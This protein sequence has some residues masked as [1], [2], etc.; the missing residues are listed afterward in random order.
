MKE[1][2]YL[3]QEYTDYFTCRK[4]INS[5]KETVDYYFEVHAYNISGYDI[6]DLFGHGLIIHDFKVV[7]K[8]EDCISLK[9]VKNYMEINIDIDFNFDDTLELKTYVYFLLGILQAQSKKE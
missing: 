4:V 8:N 6:A 7:Y 2:L 1:T 9:Y 5:A 3:L